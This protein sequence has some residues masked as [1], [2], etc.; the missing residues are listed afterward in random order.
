MRCGLRAISPAP[1]RIFGKVQ[2]NSL[3]FVKN[4]A[5][6]G[7]K[8]R[9]DAT[10][11]GTP[12]HFD[13]LITNEMFLLDDLEITGN[14]TQPLFISGN[15]RD[16]DAPRG[17]KKTGTS[18]VTLAGNN[19]FH[20]NLTILGGQVKLTAND[21]RAYPVGAINGAN[22]IVIGNAGS[23]AMD[24]GLVNVSLIDNSAGGGFQFTGG[25]LRITDFLG[26]PD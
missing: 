11:S 20:G 15:F 1:P 16:Y 18:N 14:G 26:Q 7:P 24:S 8:I 25:E 5:G 9:M 13:F 2:D 12:S 22:S 10:S 4:L 23:F 6:D 17:I 21:P 19:T 3:I